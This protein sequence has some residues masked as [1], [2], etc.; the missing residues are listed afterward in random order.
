M[1]D[2]KHTTKT[3]LAEEIAA[4][5]KQLAEVEAER[6]GFRELAEQQDKALKEFVDTC[7][8]WREMYYDCRNHPWRNLWTCLVCGPIR[9]ESNDGEV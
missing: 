8:G 9:E 3:E 1:M 7:N 2:L 5:R 6:D 4:L